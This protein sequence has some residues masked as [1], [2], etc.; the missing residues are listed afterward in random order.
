MYEYIISKQEILYF[1]TYNLN[2]QALA[3]DP[4]KVILKL[5]FSIVPLTMKD[6]AFTRI[7][8]QHAYDIGML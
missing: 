8:N 2:K 5:N 4:K 1:P 6:R 3:V 7:I